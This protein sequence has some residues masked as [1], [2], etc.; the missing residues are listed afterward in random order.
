MVGQRHFRPRLIIVIVVLWV[1]LLSACSGNASTGTTSTNSNGTSN[2]TANQ[3][4]TYSSP[5]WWN[6]QDCNKGNY[7]AAYSL[8]GYNQD[9]PPKTWNGIEVCGPTGNNPGP[10]ESFPGG[11]SQYMFQCT[12]L[13]ARYLLAYKQ[14]PSQVANGKDV[15]NVYTGLQ[16]SPFHKVDNSDSTSSVY[17]GHIQIAPVEGDVL[18]YAPAPD[19]NFNGHTSIV[20]GSTV[21]S[22]GTG[23]ISVIQQNIA[24]NGS[25]IPIDQLSVQGW[26]IQ[27]STQGAG[28]VISWMTT[29]PVSSQQPTPNTPTSTIKPGGLWI[30]PPSPNNGDTVTDVIHFAAHA[31]PTNPGDPA[32]AKVNFTVS[33]QGSWKVA[34]TA[35]PPATGDV[36]SCDANLKDLGVSYG[37]IQVSFDVYDQAGNVNLAPNGVHTLTYAPSPGVT[38]VP[39][40]PIPPTPMPP[41]PVPPTPVPP[42]PIPPTPVPPT[43]VPPTPT[44]APVTLPSGTWQDPYGGAN[45]NGDSVNMTISVQGTSVSGTMTGNLANVTVPCSGTTGPLSSF[46]SQDQGYL[47][48]VIQNYG[49]GT[50]V[51]LVVTISADFEGVGTSGSTYYMVLQNDG[52]L[53]GF[54]YMPNQSVDAGALTFNRI[55]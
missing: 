34:C 22:S 47:N 48:N 26:V 13:V 43:P 35:S 25:A 24:F 32:I 49:S 36:F 46:S 50:G 12:E 21:D 19:N 33:S 51:F 40:T 28:S 27:P 18:S 54:W 10:E 52:R 42:T 39:P 38:P 20:T 41:T 6:G 31:Y 14:L 2:S 45:Y 23:T 11:A 5:D 3:L 17:D 55:S 44:P 15:V 29:R 16:N 9:G 53:Q 30:S 37:Q 7:P 4:G 8:L 1:M